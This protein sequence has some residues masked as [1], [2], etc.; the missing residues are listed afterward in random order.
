MS[1]NGFD[2]RRRRLLEEIDDDLA[3]RDRVVKPEKPAAPAVPPLAVVACVLVAL[4]LMAVPLLL[5]W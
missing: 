3:G 2:E 5:F 1:D 4:A